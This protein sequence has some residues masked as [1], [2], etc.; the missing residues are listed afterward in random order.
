MVDWCNKIH[1]SRRLVD[2]MLHSIFFLGKI[3]KVPFSPSEIIPDGNMHDN[4]QRTYPGAFESYLTHL[5]KRSPFSCVLDMIVLQKKPENEN[6][7]KQSLKDLVNNLEPGFL[8]SSTLCVSTF[9][10]SQKSK[11]GQTSKTSVWHY[12]VSMSTSGPNPGKIVIG[13]SCLSAWEHNVA[14][15][16]MTYYPEKKKK[17]YFDGTIKL[18][19]EVKCQAYNISSGR[20]M[21]PCRS[22]GNLF[23]LQT[24]EEKE[25]PYGNCAEVESLSNLLR[26]EEVNPT[27]DNNPDKRKEAK[28]SVL[29]ELKKVLQMIK[30]NTW[31]GEFYTAQTLQS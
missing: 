5:P 27:P 19:A 26:N 1:G 30:Y 2:E 28:D 10:K 6:Q 24:L 3:N 16:V 31:E 9:I 23:G 14:G 17:P 4:L 7:I 21:N 20:E 15:A 12:G 8:V 29:K 11:C 18:P 13:C 25:W 22:C